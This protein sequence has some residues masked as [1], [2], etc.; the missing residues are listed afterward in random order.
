MTTFRDNFALLA[1]IALTV[2]ATGDRASAYDTEGCLACHQYRG[3]SRISDDGKGIEL[4]YVDPNY[5]NTPR[6][7]HSRLKCTDCHIRKEVE[8][9]PHRPQ[10]PV[11]CGKTC[12]LD[13]PNQ[14]EVRFSH[15]H[16]DEMLK[17]SVHGDDCLTQSNQLLGSPLKQGQSQC[18][19]CHDEPLFSRGGQTLVAIGSSDRPV[20]HVSRRAIVGGYAA[21][22]L[23]CDGEDA[24]GADESGFGAAVRDV[25]QQRGGP[26]QIQHAGHDGQ[27]S[28]QLSRQG[29]IAGERGD[30]Q[31][32]Q[33]S[34]G[35]G[36]QRASDRG[37]YGCD[38]AGERGES[39]GHVP[40][41]GLPPGGGRDD[42]FRGGPSRFEPQPE[43]R[44]LH[45][46]PVR[47]C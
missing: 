17:H 21:V 43:R 5:Y 19:L 41:A 16:V 33:L 32:P 38:V 29:D 46:L 23:A 13:G 18:L 45:R 14:V 42:Q 28:L 20:Q 3:L 30:G 15:G 1:I 8:V 4:F 37:A 7:P 24:A 11:D 9:F 31:L 47:A 26:R 6:G 12:H 2:L 34:R 27:L 36:A 22:L 44:I 39:A 40:A 35:S 10:T 25:P